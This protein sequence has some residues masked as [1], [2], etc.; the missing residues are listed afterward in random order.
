ML[1]KKPKSQWWN[2][3]SPVC[4][5]DQRAQVGAE[6]GRQHVVAPVSQVDRRWPIASLSVCQGAGSD[7]VSDVSN[8][9][10]QLQI[11]IGQLPATDQWQC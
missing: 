11:T 8:V 4:A 9:D 2:W 1:I 7:E 6:D 5:T 3:H 10:T